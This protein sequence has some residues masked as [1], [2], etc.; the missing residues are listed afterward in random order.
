MFSKFCSRVI[1]ED[2]EQRQERHSYNFS[3]CTNI[4]PTKCTQTI[5]NIQYVCLT[6][7]ENHFLP[8]NCRRTCSFRYIHLGLSSMHT[9]QSPWHGKHAWIFL[10]ARQK[11]KRFENTIHLRYYILFIGTKTQCLGGSSLLRIV[12]TFT[13]IYIL[14]LPWRLGTAS[15]APQVLRVSKV[16]FPFK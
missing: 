8:S 11:E 13:S 7:G 1:A 2:K 9:V 6:D 4:H 3:T 12:G 16:T 5:Q 15:T 10:L 14:S